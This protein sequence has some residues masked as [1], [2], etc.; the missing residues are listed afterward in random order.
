MREVLNTIW[1]PSF[2]Y[3]G[4]INSEMLQGVFKKNPNF[5]LVAHPQFA[6]FV[7]VPG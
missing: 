3:D 1:R 4:A 6:V 5:P 2:I 7:T